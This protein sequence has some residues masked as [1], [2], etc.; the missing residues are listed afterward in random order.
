MSGSLAANLRRA[1]EL[2]DRLA[3]MDPAAVDE[4]QDMI[5][6]LSTEDLAALRAALDAESGTGERLPGGA[7]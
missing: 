1:H 5:R 6:S 7:S 2:Q 3:A 4:M